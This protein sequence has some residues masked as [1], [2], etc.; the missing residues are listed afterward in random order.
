MRCS[1]R[2]ES[3]KINF[4]LNNSD[5]VR[6][7]A[8]YRE[9]V[10]EGDRFGVA[11]RPEARR[12]REA[13]KADRC[14]P[15]AAIHAEE[16][17]IAD[18]YVNEYQVA[19][20]RETELAATVAQLAGESGVSNQAQI[21]MRELESSAETLR[22]LYNSFL[23]KFKEVNTV[24]TETMPVQNARIITRA[25]PPLYKSSKEAAG[26]SGGK[27]VARPPFGLRARHGTRMGG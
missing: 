20:A 9:L 13:S 5:L 22:N 18:V 19:K 27:H 11:R 15:Q 1:T 14:R 21:T 26:D 10:G 2:P 17:R 6:L 12:R 23:Q 24:Q 4:A 3:G 7:R 16:K 8:Q 25:A